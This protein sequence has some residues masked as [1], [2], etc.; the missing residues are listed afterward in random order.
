MAAHAPH[1]RTGYWP[2]IVPRMHC[3]RS[4]VAID[5]AVMP[6]GTLPTIDNRFRKW[7]TGWATAP[8]SELAGGCWRSKWA[9]SNDDSAGARESEF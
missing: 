4:R 3:G 7:L 5:P 9:S 8:A 6:L 2:L 1:A